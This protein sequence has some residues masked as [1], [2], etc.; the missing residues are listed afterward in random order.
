[1]CLDVGRALERTPGGVECF[2]AELDDA[3]GAEPRLDRYTAAL[4]DELRPGREI[5]RRIVERMMLALQAALLVGHAPPAVADAF[6][7]GRLQGGFTGAFGTL[8]DGTDRDAIVRR[9]QPV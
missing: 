9:A 3:R 4:R 2:F 8:P 6:C 7:A 1:M 5:G